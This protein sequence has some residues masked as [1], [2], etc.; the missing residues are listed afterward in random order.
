V[1]VIIIFSIH[2]SVLLS[3]HKLMHIIPPQT[4]NVS[5]GFLSM[6]DNNWQQILKL[7]EKKH[8]TCQVTTYLYGI[9]SQNVY[10]MSGSLEDYSRDDMPVA[11]IYRPLRQRIYGVLLH[12]KPTVKTVKEWCVESSKVPSQPTDVPVLRMPSVGKLIADHTGSF[13]FLF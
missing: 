12:E 6:Q 4:T 10:Q 11:K 9:I 2:F 1:Q 7:A 5:P 8:R 3:V 13:K